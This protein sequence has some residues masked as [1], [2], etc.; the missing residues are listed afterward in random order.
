MGLETILWDIAIVMLA[1]FLLPFSWNTLATCYPKGA[2]IVDHELCFLDVAT[3]VLLRK[4]KPIPSSTIRS[5]TYGQTGHRPQGK[6]LLLNCYMDLALKQILMTYHSTHR[7]VHGSYC[8]WDTSVCTWW[9][10]RLA[11]VKKIRGCILFSPNG[12]HILHPPLK[13]QGSFLKKG[14]KEGNSQR[15]QT[16]TRKHLDIAGIL[17]IRTQSSFNHTH[18]ACASLSQT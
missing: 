14:E 3:S 17:H 7:P 2:S 18:K 6:L 8:S 4:M 11:H 1:C 16:T 5:R 9:F 10:P 13:A 15:G 12:T